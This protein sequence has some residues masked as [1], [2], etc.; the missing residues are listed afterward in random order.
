MTSYIKNGVLAFK[1]TSHRHFLKIASFGASSGIASYFLFSTVAV[2][3]ADSGVP[4]SMRGILLW[5]SLPYTLKLFLSPLIETFTF[6]VL[7]RKVGKKKSWILL[8]QL[9]IVLSLIALSFVNLDKQLWLIAPICFFMALC[10]ALQDNT[11]EVY[12]IQTTPPDQQN[13]GAQANASGYRIGMW[14]AG[15]VPL[16][17]A[18]YLSWRVAFWVVAAFVFIGMCVVS[19]MKEPPSSPPLFPKKEYYKRYLLLI[20]EGV[21]FFKKTYFFGSILLV[22]V[23]LKMTDIFIRTLLAP[24]FL[25]QG[26]TT[27]DL[28]NIDKSLGIVSMLVGIY[29]GSRLIAKKGIPWA[30]RVWAMSQAMVTLLFLVQAYTGKNYPLLV[31]SLSVNNFVGGIGATVWM[32]YLSGLCKIKKQAIVVEYALL[33][34]FGSFSRL[35]SGSCAEL[36]IDLVSWPMCFM[37][38]F[39]VCIPLFLMTWSAKPFTQRNTL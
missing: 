16:L 39:M 15:C 36:T 26:Y 1:R 38:N 28:A 27:A 33:T 30:M 32:T 11:L 17:F 4:A 37:I 7:T 24:F 3:L 21:L 8:S 14:I 2:W 22:I 19:T 34:S 12:R 20:Q 31:A 25:E 29:L 6:G 23:F 9:G 13:L 10:G 35:F 5:A 18:H